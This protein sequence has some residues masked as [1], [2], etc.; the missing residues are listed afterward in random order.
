MPRILVEPFTIAAESIDLNGH[1]NNQ[2]Y[3]RWM[4]DIATAHSHEQ[5]WTVARY[6]DTGT[7]WVIRSHYIEYIRPAFLGDD[8]MVATWVAGIAEQTSPR[9]YRFVRARDGKTVVEAETLWVYCDATTGRPLAISPEIRAAFPVVGDETEITAAI[10]DRL[11][12][13]GGDR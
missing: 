9:K 6:L 12:D 11:A 2:E 4:Q 7:T 8:L 13:T 5:G 3:V 10:A 1:V